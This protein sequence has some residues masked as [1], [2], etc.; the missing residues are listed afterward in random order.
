MNFVYITTNHS[1]NVLYTGVTNSLE[2]RIIQHYQ[3]RGNIKSFAG[4]YSCYNLLHY[5]QFH[6]IS[7]AIRREKLIKN[8][9]RQWK[10]ALISI[11]NPEWVFL[12]EMVFGVWLPF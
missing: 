4:K 1:K 10:E 9:S 2:K 3:N 6:Y 12:N 8:R 5:E 7:D 11:E